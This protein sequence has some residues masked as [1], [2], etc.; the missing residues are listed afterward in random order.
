MSTPKI[1]ALEAH[2]LAL[3]F[4]DL[5]EK[6]YGELLIDIRDNGQ[7]API[8]LFEGKILDGKNRYRVCQEL[9]LEPI[10]QDYEGEDPAAYV[11]SLNIQRRHLTASQRAVAADKISAW[12]TKGRPK[13]EANLPIKK[14]DVK[15]ASEQLGVSGRSTRAA[16][17]VRQEAPKEVR[18]A[19]ESGEVKVSDAGSIAKKPHSVQ[20]QAL[21]DVRAGKTKTL[22]QSVKN[23]EKGV[24]P[25]GSTINLK[26]FPDEARIQI[27]G[28]IATL[29]KAAET[30]SISHFNPKDKDR[31]WDLVIKLAADHKIEITKTAPAGKTVDPEDHR[32]AKKLIDKVLERF[33]HQTKK[34]PAADDLEN[35]RILRGRYGGE[36]VEEIIDWATEHTSAKFSWRD[37]IRSTAKLKKHIEDLIVQK[38]AK[39]KRAKI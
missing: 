20:K 16:R 25:S 17:K 10:T 21:E 38:D 15:E 37:V 32:L 11:I 19:L 18:E 31:V 22:A 39:P 33:P 36:V 14:P 9:G 1:T 29:N 27:R 35:I 6:A 26:E 2:D 30:I 8:V 4:P 24:R 7:L 13:K 23:Q 5:S 3:A 12:S 28:L 34:A